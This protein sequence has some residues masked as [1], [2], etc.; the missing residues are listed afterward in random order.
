LEFVRGHV[1]NLGLVRRNSRSREG[2]CALQH[3][4]VADE[5]PLVPNCEFHFDVVPPLED[6]YFALQNDSQA[7][8]ALSGFVHDVPALCDTALPERFKQR[9]LMIV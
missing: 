3:R 4:N 9:K 1:K 6:L 2:R 8:I 7:N 5:I